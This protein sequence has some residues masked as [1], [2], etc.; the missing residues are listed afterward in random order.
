MRR[1]IQ[2]RGSANVVYVDETG[3]AP[4]ACRPHGW[5]ARGQRVYGEHAGRRWPRTNL[6]AARRGSEFFATVLFQGNVHADVV[7]TWMRQILCKELRPNST[8]I[9]D[10]AA[11]HRKSDLDAIAAEHGHHILFLPPYSPDFNPIERDFANLKKRRRFAP[12]NT[13]LETLVREYGNYVV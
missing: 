4:E 10:N 8:I 2:E 12:P 6:I 5:S 1:I 11:F 7:N 9:W 13:P 3:F